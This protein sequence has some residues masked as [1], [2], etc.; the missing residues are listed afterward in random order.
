MTSS[1]ILLVSVAVAALS[2]AVVAAQQAPA[3]RGGAGLNAPPPIVWPSPPLPDGPLSVDTGLVRPVEITIVKGFT[4]PFGMAFLPD[5]A[6]LVTERPGRL[7]I[8][9]DGTLD[10]AP[11]AGVPRVQAQGLQGLMDI[12]LHPQFAENHLVYLTYHKP[13]PG[14]STAP[15]GRGNATPPGTITLA[16]GRWDGG[17]LVDVHDIFSALPSGNA[18][19]IAF[20]RDGMIYMSVGSGDPPA[21]NPNPSTAPAQ[22]PMSLAG[23]VLRLRDDGTV[24]RDNPFV[25]RP[26][27]RAE[28][29]TLGHRNILGL[30]LNP[31]TGD[32]WSVEDGPNGGDELNALA[33]G[34]NY[35][36]PLVSFGRFYLGQQVSVQPY[37]EGLE[38]PLAFW[39]PAI[40]TSGL[41]FYTGDRFPQWKN[42]AFVGGMRT[43][44]VPRSGHLE[45][46]DFNEKWEELHRE[47]LLRD[48][49]QRVRDVRQGPDGLLYVLT[50]EDQGALLR[51]APGAKTGS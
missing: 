23:K 50:A 33:A 11:V 10:P 44:E 46:L 35:G 18:S 15:A 17:K 36:W 40:A 9:R 8:V 42:S 7:R 12:A 43:G 26:G 48:L 14:A 1:R 41:A 22:D 13:A 31:V 47:G 3:R 30:A 4:Q 16:R 49:Q 20:G 45:R 32:M 2:V 27:Y 34:K 19:R 39:V 37:R 51:L 21:G 24:P 25:G 28:I 38:P 6:I 5:G 29:F